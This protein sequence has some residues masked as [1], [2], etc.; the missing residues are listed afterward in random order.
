ME[1][2]RST[3]CSCRRCE[4]TQKPSISSNNPR[5][6]GHYNGMS[7]LGWAAGV[8]GCLLLAS[9]AGSKPVSDAAGASGTGGV[10]PADFTYS[11]TAANGDP[12]AVLSSPGCGKAFPLNQQLG[13]YTEYLQHVTGQTLDPSFSVAPHDRGYYVWLPKDYESTRPYRVTF[14]FAGCGSR[15]DA[16]QNT[17]KLMTADPEAIYVAMNLPPPG[18]PPEGRDCYDTFS[19]PRSIELEFMGSVGSALQNQFC[20][21]ENRLFVA[22]YSSG[23]TLADQL[24]CYFAGKDPQRK[25]GPDVSVRGM[26]G[27]TGAIPSADYACGAKVAALWIDNP[28]SNVLPISLVLDTSLP[29]VLSV[30]GCTAGSAGP[31]SAWGSSADLQSGCVHYDAC[32]SGYSVVLCKTTACHSAAEDLMLPGAIEFENSMNPG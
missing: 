9:C 27:V 3:S 17:Y 1:P 13:A 30:D 7:G 18:L 5:L 20:V 14:L 19:G 26:L 31:S 15:D 8:V 25:F 32:P 16:D 4:G 23:A 12:S 29:R 22:G 11:A 2:A 24:G 10:G 28:D 6:A 21:D